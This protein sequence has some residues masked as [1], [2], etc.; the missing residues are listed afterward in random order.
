MTDD[1][2]W[3]RAAIAEA[4]KADGLTS[5]NP[6]VGAVI[7]RDG[8]ILARDYHRKAGDAHA[9]VRAI[10]DCRTRHGS[11]STRGATIYVTLEPCSTT[12]K[13]PPCTGAIAAAGLERVVFGS[14]DPNPDHQGKASPILAAGGIEVTPSVLADE[15]DA[16]LAPWAKFITT[17]LPWVIGKAAVS[18]DGRLTRPPGEGQWLTGD[19]ARAHA[20]RYRRRADAILVGANTV[21]ADNPKLTVRGT[22]GRGK[23]QPWRCI[24]SR[25]KSLPEDSH[26]F[27]DKHFKRTLVFEEGIE[28]TLADLASRGVVTVLIEGGGQILGEA[29][30]RNLVDEVSFYIAPI[31]CGSG[32]APMVVNS[33]RQSHRLQGITT[34]QI[35]DDIHVGGRISPHES[36]N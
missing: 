12:G 22:Q 15:C 11:D 34:K 8:K 1:E 29:F 9:E 14:T 23:S 28:N 17:G 7:V 33:L 35:G 21:R 5:P 13:T 16:V 25:S 27:T 20:M 32:C 3:M 31:V 6:P 24:L 10:E 30:E 2:K 18:L 26:L 19:K 4:R 36:E